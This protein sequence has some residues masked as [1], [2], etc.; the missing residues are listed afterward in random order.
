[1]LLNSFIP[2]DGTFMEIYFP[3]CASPVLIDIA[4]Y[5]ILK[6]H[7]WRIFKGIYTNYVACD[8]TRRQ[9]IYLH[10]ALLGK[11]PRGQM[12]D[13]LNHNG[14]DN[15]R[16]NINVVT[17]RQNNLNRTKQRSNTSGYVGVIYQYGRRGRDVLT[18]PWLARIS[19]ENRKRVSVGNYATKEE[20]ALAYNNAALKYYGKFAILNK[21]SPPMEAASTKEGHPTCA[22]VLPVV[23]QDN[24]QISI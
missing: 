12:I 8:L 23:S 10:Q 2:Q 20:A 17:R 11:P 5:D 1:M 15:R 18:K 14:L 22:T 3:K 9:I 16:C 6:S 13:H 7:K 4:D 24:T 21:I 19:V